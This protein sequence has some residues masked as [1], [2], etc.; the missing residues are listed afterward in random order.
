MN[1]MN[2]LQCFRKRKIKSSKY[3]W[4]LGRK[5]KKNIKNLKKVLV[6]DSGKK[7]MVH[8]N[9][10]GTATEEWIGDRHSYS[11]MVSLYKTCAKEVGDKLLKKAEVERNYQCAMGL[12]FGSP[13]LNTIEDI[14]GLYR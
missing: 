11:M 8:F 10:Y 3:V 13:Q 9:K 6:F 1:D 14:E 7:L 4:G 2:I 12:C 5:G